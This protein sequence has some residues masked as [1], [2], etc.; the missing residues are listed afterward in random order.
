ML[1][2]MKMHEFLD[3]LA[4]SSP[5]PGGGSASALLCSIGASLLCMVCNLT[6]GKKE[7]EQSEAE[8]KKILGEAEILRKKAE[9]LI[10]EDSK[11]FN[12]VME[13]YKTPKENPLR[14]NII[15]EALRNA[16]FAPLQIA[17][18]GIRVLEFS[19]IVAFKG[20]VKSISDVGVAVLA[21]NGGVRG[22]LMNV[23]INLQAMREDMPKGEMLNKVKS[24]EERTKILFDEVNGTILFRLRN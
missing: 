14:P 13:A 22:A 12:V 16:N 2:D 1:S 15:Q 7:Y 6:I 5:A 20:N 17:E 4:S 11:A 10:D 19:K 23:R 3:E 9:V 18:I 8:L 24:M 21:A